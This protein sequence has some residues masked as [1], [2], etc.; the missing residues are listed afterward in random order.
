M[1]LPAEYLYIAYILIGLFIVISVVIIVFIFKLSKFL[2][3]TTSSLDHL[4]KELSETLRDLS[5]DIN[6]MKNKM[7]TTLDGVNIVTNQLTITAKTID[8]ELHTVTGI[9]GPVENLVN[10]VYHKIF[11]PVNQVASLIS[12]SSKAINT[13]VAVLTKGRKQ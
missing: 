6:D 13:F 7:I 1:E 9:L 4:S 12:A 8:E 2:S 5:S 3:D 10:T 11:L